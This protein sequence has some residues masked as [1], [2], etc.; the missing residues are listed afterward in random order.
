MM[1]CQPESF[2]SPLFRILRQLKA[3]SKSVSYGFAFAYGSEI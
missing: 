2:I 1:L 3:I